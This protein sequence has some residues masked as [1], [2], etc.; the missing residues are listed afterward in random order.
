MFTGSKSTHGWLNGLIGVGIFAGS[1]PATKLAI[2]SFNPTF[3]TFARASIAGVLAVLILIVLKQKLPN[4]HEVYQLVIVSFGVVIG[5]PLFTALALQHISTTHSIIFV[6][7]LPLVTAICGIILGERKPQILFWLFAITGSVLVS[8]FS[9]TLSNT[10]HSLL[11]NLYMLLAILTCGIGY[12]YGGKLSRSLG[13]W[14]V[15]C[16][17]LV[18][19]L[20][21]MLLLSILSFIH[22]PIWNIEIKAIYG[23]A[24][25]SIFSMLIGFIFWY[26]GL[27]QGGVVAIGQLQL[28]QP[29][30]GLL[31]C[32][33]LLNESI[34]WG[35]IG[36]CLAICGCVFLAKK[37]A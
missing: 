8:G 9:L 31:L 28:L 17:A 35:M 7:M 26:K 13:G 16:W 33:F 15:I 25:V 6:G 20:P 24:Y 36:V 5:F 22:H 11:G 4:K 3:L 2:I 30:L 23:L 12:A 18:I 34:I 37:Y 21:L 14:Q 19:A 27:A 1:L 29:F 32:Y 10:D